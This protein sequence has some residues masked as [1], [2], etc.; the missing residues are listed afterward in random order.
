MEAAGSFEMLVPVFSN[1]MMSHPGR[2]YLSNGYCLW[3][4]KIFSLVMSLEN[5]NTDISFKNVFVI[6]VALLGF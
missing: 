4:M 3:D 2:L 1:Y 5:L 6:G